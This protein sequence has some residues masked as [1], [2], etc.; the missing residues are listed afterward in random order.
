MRMILN[1]NSGVKSYFPIMLFVNVNWFKIPG[2][3][4]FFQD[5]GRHAGEE[6]QV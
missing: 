2:R 1:S 5:L 3:E 4:K 6:K